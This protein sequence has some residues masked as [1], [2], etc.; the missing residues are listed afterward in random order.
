MYKGHQNTKFALSL[1]VRRGKHLPQFLRL[2]DVVEDRVQ[3][4]VAKYRA[5]LDR[6]RTRRHHHP[7]PSLFLS[8]SLDRAVFA[9][10][11]SPVSSLLFSFPGL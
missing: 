7:P 11:V 4:L 9:C 2:Q 5:A 10:F 6:V 1:L 3:H 8:F